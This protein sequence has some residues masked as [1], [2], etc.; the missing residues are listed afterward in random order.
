MYRLPNVLTVTAALL[1]TAGVSP[2]QDAKQEARKIEPD[3]LFKKLDANNDGK[4]SR[5]EFKKVTE[6]GLV[7][8]KDR[9][10]ILDKLFDRLDA[11]ADGVLSGEEFG[12]FGSL[13]KRIGDAAGQPQAGLIGAFKDAEATFKKLDADKD[14]KLS[15]DEFGKFLDQANVPQLKERA[16]KLFGRLDADGNG[17]LSLDEFKKMADFA[18][19]LK[20][21]DK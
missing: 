16:E 19:R 12:K 5:E 11:N 9:A 20:K 10:E 8:L 7:R 21:G 1:L 4:L 18:Q 15:K 2:A 3:K 14:G 6:L 17:S 13:A